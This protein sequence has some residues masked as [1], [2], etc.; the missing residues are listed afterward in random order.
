MRFTE[1]WVLIGLIALPWM[2]RRG[3]GVVRGVVDGLGTVGAPASL[4]ANAASPRNRLAVLLLLALGFVASSLG[5]AGLEGPSHTTLQPGR[6]L[7]VL[8]AIDTSRSMATRDVSPDRLTAV[9]LLVE[10]V[11]SQLKG[12][13]F[14]L[15]VFAGVAH[16]QCPFTADQ[17]IIRR[18]LQQLETGTLP[19]GGTDL[20]AVL[21]LAAETGERAGEGELVLLLLTD[22]EDHREGHS[23]ARAMEA[24]KKLNALGIVSLFVAVGS[25]LGEPI[26]DGEGGYIED[27]AGKP[28]VSRA[29]RAGLAQLAEAAGG[30]FLVLEPGSDAAAAIETALLGMDRRAQRPIR[31]ERRDPWYQWA[32]ALGL[33]SFGLG[34]SLPRSAGLLLLLPLLSGFTGPTHLDP[35]VVRGRAAL[36]AGEAQR[37]LAYFAAARRRGDHP[38][39]DFNEGLAHGLAGDHGEAGRAFGRAAARLTGPAQAE[40]FAAKGAALARSGDKKEAIK[41]LRNALIRQPG[42]PAARSWLRHLLAAPPKPPNDKKDGDDSEGDDRSE[43]SDGGPP[44]DGGGKGENPSEPESGG[45]DSGPGPDSGPDP[46]AAGD[47]EQQ[48]S[49]GVNDRPDAGAQ[50]DGGGAADPV[51]SGDAGQGAQAGAQGQPKTD[52]GPQVGDN[53]LENYRARER[54][55]PYNRWAPPVPRRPVEKDW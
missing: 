40:A 9:R 16:L 25:E 43:S 30:R 50:N 7:D 45:G 23:E 31:V 12:D 28:V 32:I 3:F 33:F 52:A 15:S 29:D 54:L 47:G 51:P 38:A 13:R 42:H 14:A 39:I 6:G 53:L 21:E 2:W 41:A 18:Y 4:R 5:A 20:V 24:A 11:A 17:A 49:P 34:L 27:R 26:P 1:P 44:S 19:G 10:G 48:P 36:E 8:V 46:G 35:D 37:A 55:L 22:G